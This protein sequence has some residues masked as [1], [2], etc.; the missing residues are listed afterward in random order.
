MYGENHTLV[1]DRSTLEVWNPQ[2]DEYGRL[3]RDLV[4]VPFVIT[5]D[6]KGSTSARFMAIYLEPGPRF[7][8]DATSNPYRRIMGPAIRLYQTLRLI[9]TRSDGR[10]IYSARYLFDLDAP[11]VRAI[12]PQTAPDAPGRAGKG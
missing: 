3:I 2:Y 10:E 12:A 4:G 11:P 5:L 7:D 8:P 6:G 1:I 9:G